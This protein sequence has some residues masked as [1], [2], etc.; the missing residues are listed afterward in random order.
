MT[1]LDLENVGL[2]QEQC[3]LVR[4]WEAQLPPVIAR[5]EVGW[6]LGGIIT[7]GCLAKEDSRGKGP[8]GRV[9]IGSCVAY[10]TRNLLVWLVQSRGM[11]QLR[12]VGDFLPGRERRLSSA[13][14]VDLPRAVSL[15]G[16]DASI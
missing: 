12:S 13:A 9:A 3:D 1:V 10:H 5:K 7:T 14:Q 6:F 2:T 8:M 4:C 11:E 16:Q 15:R